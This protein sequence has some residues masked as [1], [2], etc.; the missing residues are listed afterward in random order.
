MKAVLLVARILWAV[1]LA[2][3]GALAR[4]LV[5]GPTVRSW[6]WSAELIVA[7]VRAYIVAGSPGG[8]RT[9]RR[10]MESRF[11]PPLPR[12][13]RS[14]L[15]T[16]K[17]T[18]GGVPGEWITRVGEED[19][20]GPTILY[21]HGGAYITGSPAT[22][23]RF[24]ARLTWI[25]RARS[26]LA[27]YRLAPQHKFP[28]A[29]EDA[30]AAYD[31]LIELGV[32]P[33]RLFVAGDSAGGGLACAL[34]QRLR[35]TGRP[36]P[37]GTI[38]F[39]P[40]TDLEHTAPS[41]RANAR[42]DYLPVGEPGAVNRFYVG[43]ADPRDPLISPIYG[44]YRNVTPLLVCAGGKE[45]ILDDSVRLVEKARRDGAEVTFHIE[46]DMFHV[47]PAFLPN[48]P[49]TRRTMTRVAGFVLDRNQ[50]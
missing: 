3:A 21:F 16:R 22:H 33:A 13:L 30:E 48:H 50:N 35:D 4:R 6:S 40:Y 20:R 24:V 19:A 17:A 11:N 45:M 14:V 37:A 28:D 10:K 9:T 49:A 44:D 1:T 32:Q 31:A 41:I 2:M 39:S 42:T 29:L 46:E 38:L 15:Q 27:D 8:D 47:W 36:L 26:F 34:L 7:A 5:R 43:D 23:R 18:L 25:T 12:S